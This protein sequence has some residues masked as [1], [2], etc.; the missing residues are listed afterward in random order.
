MLTGMDWWRISVSSAQIIVSIAME[1]IKN[2]KYVAV[3]FQFFS[4]NHL[5]IIREGNSP[6]FLTHD[7]TCILPS[8]DF[9]Y[10]R[11]MQKCGAV[12]VYNPDHVGT[13]NWIVTA[14]ALLSINFFDLSY[15]EDIDLFLSCC[16]R[17]VRFLSLPFFSYHIVKI[18]P[19]VYYYY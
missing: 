7:G 16:C 4:G 18:M 13:S 2:A 19:L 10:D 5:S 14:E 3:L 8:F 1:I 15:V 9:Y 12:G 6:Y 11:F 17:N